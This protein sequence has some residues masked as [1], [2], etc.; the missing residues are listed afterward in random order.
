[1]TAASPDR[2]LTATEAAEK[3]GVHR[4]TVLRWAQAGKV[5]VAAR[6]GR[7]LLFDPADLQP[8]LRDLSQPV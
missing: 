2:L 6:A 1:M 4:A 7:M 3:V 8:P 5:P